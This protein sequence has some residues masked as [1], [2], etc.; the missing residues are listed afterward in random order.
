MQTVTIAEKQYEL[1]ELPAR[2]A[3]IWRKTLT[4]QYG[5]LLQEIMSVMNT[6]YD[7][8]EGRAIIGKLVGNA[9][10]KL[11]GSI[12]DIRELVFNYIPALQED[13]D[14]ALDNGLDSE[15]LAAFVQ[16]IKLAYP[17]GGIA[18][19][20]TGAIGAVNQRTSKN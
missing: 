7:S 16:V 8:V 14:Y 6:D 18:Q 12:E 4:D 20:V 13:R 15:F 5:T 10:F 1:K 2:K 17:F 9:V 3:T 19:M 11:G